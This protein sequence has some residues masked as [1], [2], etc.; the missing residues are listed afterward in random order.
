MTPFKSYLAV[1]A[2]LA[3]LAVGFF[4]WRGEGVQSVPEGF[5][6]GN[7]RIEAVE[8]DVASKYPGRIDTVLVHEGELVE[9]G[10]PLVQLDIRQVKAARH[11]AE[12]ELRRAEI[13]VEI[14]RLVIEQRRSEVR[15]AEAVLAQRQAADEVAQRQLTRSTSLA[16]SSV[17]SERTLEIDRSNALEAAAAVASA[18]AALAA[19]QAGVAAAEA[20]AIGS[21]AAVAAAKAAIEAIDV[22]IEDSTLKAPRKGRVQY[23][24]AREGEVISAGGRV[25]NMVDLNEVYMTFFLRTADAGRAG[26]GSEVRLLL[27]AAPDIAIPASISFVSDVAQFTPKTVETEVERE[28]LMFRVRARI[29]PELLAKYLDYIK[30]GLPGVAWVR[31]DPAAPWPEAAGGRVLE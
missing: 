29:A 3:L 27:D 14:A 9:A 24:V 19:A 25:V 21:E 11:Q 6:F 1:G 10:Q 4:F 17:A 7:G 20:S 31:L 18:E 13:S 12:A 15:A 30:T 16:E 5:A 2:G 26:L 28:K 8:I 23:L 22:Q